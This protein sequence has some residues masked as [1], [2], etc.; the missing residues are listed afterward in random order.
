MSSRSA[1]PS[2]ND[3]STGD[4]V[5]DKPSLPAAAAAACMQEVHRA[6]R[7]GDL[8]ECVAFSGFV[9]G[10]HSCVCVC[11]GD[12]QAGGRRRR[13]CVCLPSLLEV[14]MHLKG[15]FDRTGALTLSGFSFFFL[16]LFFLLMARQKH[17]RMSPSVL[18]PLG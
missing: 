3:R 17:P 12:R 4:H 15:E 14:M 7:G 1:L 10:P 6:S 9:R 8:I 11:V 2:G 16:L 18:L 5:S 13:W